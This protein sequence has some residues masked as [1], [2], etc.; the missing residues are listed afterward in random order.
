MNVKRVHD[1]AVA[2]FHRLWSAA[3]GTPGYNKSDWIAVE[4]RLHYGCRGEHV[5]RGGLL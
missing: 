5:A 2:A 4:R 3:V 1:E